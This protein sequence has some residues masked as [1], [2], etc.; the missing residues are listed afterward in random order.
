MAGRQCGCLPGSHL[1]LNAND[2]TGINAAVF[3]IFRGRSRLSDIPA[4]IVDAVVAFPDVCKCIDQY[5]TPGIGIITYILQSACF[6][7]AP[8]VEIPG[9]WGAG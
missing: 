7:S 9:L 8:M 2:G 4:G 1:C 5:D 6:L 3:F